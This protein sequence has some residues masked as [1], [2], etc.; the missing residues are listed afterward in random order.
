MLALFVALS[1]VAWAA[2]TIGAGD[3]KTNAVRSKHI[4]NGEVKRGDIKAGAVNSAKVKDDSLT[5][6][7]I[8]ESALGTVPNASKVNGV[9]VLSVKHRSGD[10]ADVSFFNPGGLQLRVSCTA[11][12]E[13]VRARTTIAGGEISVVSDDADVADGS[14]AGISHQSDND[15]GP[16]DEIDITEAIPAVDSRVYQ[17]HYSGGDGR[18]VSA[19]L[20]TESNIGTSICVVSGYAV[21]IG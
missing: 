5:G 2:A 7:D 8:N 15:F 9:R 6:A 19:N 18:I 20:A 12:D 16:G 11:G 10:V 13:E 14:A 21:V 3:I 1:G 17:L 4:K